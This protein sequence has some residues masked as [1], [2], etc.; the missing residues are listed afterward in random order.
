LAPEHEFSHNNCNDF[1]T[2]SPDLSCDNPGMEI[3]RNLT[4]P[5]NSTP[6]TNNP[7]KVGH[8]TESTEDLLSIPEAAVQ[9]GIDDFS[10]Y[11]LIQ[12]G[13]VQPERASSGKLIL[14]QPQVEALLQGLPENT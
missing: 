8:K 14:R 12:G 2:I 10:L 3:K 6:V 7:D 5:S 4:P 9:L 1:I 11:G 13:A